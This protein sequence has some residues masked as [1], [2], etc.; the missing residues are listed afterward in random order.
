MDGAPLIPAEFWR[1]T[2]LPGT[3]SGPKIPTVLSAEEGTRILDH[4]VKLMHFWK[5]D[6]TISGKKLGSLGG[7]WVHLA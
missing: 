2:V 3:G 7:P 4:T 5:A 1:T 6:S